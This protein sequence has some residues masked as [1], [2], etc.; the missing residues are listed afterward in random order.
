MFL[1]L[2]VLTHYINL[3]D[4]RPSMKAILLKSPKNKFQPFF[5]QPSIFS[6]TGPYK[7]TV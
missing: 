5:P 4:V 1:V 3:Q 6:L 2:Y 7:Y